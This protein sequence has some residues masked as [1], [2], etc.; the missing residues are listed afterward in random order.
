M[1]RDEAMS[2]L[3]FAQTSERDEVCEGGIQGAAGMA[4]SG[5]EDWGWSCLPRRHA[6]PP[7]PMFCWPETAPVPK[8]WRPLFLQMDARPRQ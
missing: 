3:A 2:L 8:H 7:L 6:W 4:N 5:G 1:L